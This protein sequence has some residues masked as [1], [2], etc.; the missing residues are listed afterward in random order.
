[1]SEAMSPKKPAK[2]SLVE[3]SFDS[4]QDL[5]SFMKAQ[6]VSKF[7]YDDL[8]V[9]F[10]TFPKQPAMPTLDPEQDRLQHIRN[11][12]KEEAD[13]EEADLKWSSAP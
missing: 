13:S 10:D 11:I 1:M 8:W 6:G 5:V 2:K 7:S 3:K 4:V 12:L 9:E